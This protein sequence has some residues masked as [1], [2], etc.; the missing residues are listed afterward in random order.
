[1]EKD[2]LTSPK[3]LFILL[4]IL[5]AFIKK[6]RKLRDSLLDWSD[7]HRGLEGYLLTR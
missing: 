4:V 1:M 7:G 3:S 2:L 5:P 6:G